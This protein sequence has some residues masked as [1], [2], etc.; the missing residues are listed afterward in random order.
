M[1]VRELLNLNQEE[2]YLDLCKNLDQAATESEKLT[3]INTFK[4]NNANVLKVS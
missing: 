4:M 3:L 2:I 1:V